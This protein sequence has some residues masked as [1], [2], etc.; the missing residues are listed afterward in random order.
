MSEHVDERGSDVKPK[1]EDNSLRFLTDVPFKMAASLHNQLPLGE[2]AFSG[3]SATAFDDGRSYYLYGAADEVCKAG[4]AVMRWAEFLSG[5][6][7]PTPETAKDRHLERLC[8]ESVVD[9]QGM[10][11]RKLT[12]W[13]ANLVCFSTTNEQEYYRLFLAAETYSWQLGVL[14]DLCEYYDCDSGNARI[15]LEWAR[16]RMVTELAAVD[17]ARCWFLE[18]RVFTKLPQRPGG[19]FRR[20]ARR[21]SMAFT[22]GTPDERLSLGITYGGG[23]GQASRSV[24]PAIGDVHPPVTVDDVRRNLRRVSLL[25]INVMNRSHLL[26]GVEPRGL[27]RRVAAVFCES[28]SADTQL[29]RVHMPGYDT[30]DVVLAMGHLAEVLERRVSRYGLECYRVRF[31]VRGPLKETPQDWVPADQTRAILRRRWTRDYV[32]WAL[33]CTPGP[34]QKG[35]KCS[36]L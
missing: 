20:L 12:E 13:L 10:W 24:H 8:V 26:A 35:R 15:G 19:I 7:A 25:C 32:R 21:L 3:A 17:Q 30:G 34:G 6:D 2:H 31:L 5:P 9:E 18:P 14:K 23:F 1:A 36:T 28:G 27:A 11:Q 4:I 22:H 33:D 16:D 29:R